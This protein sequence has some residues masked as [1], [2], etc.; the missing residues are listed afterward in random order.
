MKTKKIVNDP[1]NVV[2][3]LLEGLVE[4]HNGTVIKTPWSKRRGQG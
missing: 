4:A 3:E 2:P 1:K